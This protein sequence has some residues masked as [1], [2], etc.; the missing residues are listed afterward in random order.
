MRR[1]ASLLFLIASIKRSGQNTIGVPEIVNY[2][3]QSYN[4]GTQNWDIRQGQNGVLYFGNNEGLLS[5]DGTFW[6]LYPLP[7]RTI[8]RAG[9]IS[10]DQKIYTAC[11]NEFGFFAPD[12][13]GFLAY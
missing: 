6:N 7:N 11:Q 13:K 5:F 3:K 4:A 8:G 1:I 10:K 9:E 2:T 12:E